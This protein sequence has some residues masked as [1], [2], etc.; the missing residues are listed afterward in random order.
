MREQNDDFVPD[1]TALKPKER[2]G[3]EQ[4]ARRASMLKG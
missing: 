4:R 2:I 3:G 1:Q